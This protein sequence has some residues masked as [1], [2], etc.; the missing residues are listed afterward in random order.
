MKLG[1]EKFAGSMS[2]DSQFDGDRLDDLYAPR[3]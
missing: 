3:W 1:K 2:T